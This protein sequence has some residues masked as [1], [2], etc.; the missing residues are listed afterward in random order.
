[1]ILP[2]VIDSSMIPEG[3]KAHPE[4]MQ[5]IIRELA[6]EARNEIVRRAMADLHTS[7]DDYAAGLQP[8]TYKTEGGLTV[9]TIVL[10]GMIP[11]MIE[12]GWAGGDMKPFLLSG[13]NAKVA[14]DGTRY[15]VVPFRHMGPGTTGRHGQPMGSQYRGQLGRPKA[16]QLGKDVYEA[17]KGLVGK[18]SR[19][20][21]PRRLAPGHAPVLKPHHKTDIY[22]GMVKERAKYKKATQ[23]QY[24]TFRAV[25][26]KSD[27]ASW[28]HPGIEAREF[29][30]EASDYVDRVSR[31]VFDHAVRKFEV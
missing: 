20:A 17:A 23:S 26:D 9:A 3:L 4:I 10:T 29:F 8:V 25:S 24:G 18:R 31:S 6:E 11:N 30:K 22:A 1:M 14:R 28:I 5:Q 27:P 19:K 16:D 13:R 7:F 2:V 12:N 21:G 15:N